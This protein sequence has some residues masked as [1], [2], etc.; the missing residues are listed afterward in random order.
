[1]SAASTASTLW[2]SASAPVRVLVSTHADTKPLAIS[3]RRLAG[4]ACRPLANGQVKRR[5]GVTTLLDIP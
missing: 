4:L 5:S 3:A 1:M 2:A